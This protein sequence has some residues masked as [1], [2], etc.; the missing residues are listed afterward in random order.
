M[1]HAFQMLKIQAHSQCHS[2]NYYPNSSISKFLQTLCLL[3]VGESSVI[4]G[5]Q[6]AE[7][8]ID[9]IENFVHHLASACVD[10]DAAALQDD[11][12]IEIANQ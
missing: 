6:I 5:H 9:V 4:D 3:F 12:V 11:R 1:N 2:R 8:I 10:K 7:G